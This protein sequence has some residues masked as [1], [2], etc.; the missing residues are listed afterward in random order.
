MLNVNLKFIYNDIE[1]KIQANKDEIMKEIFK[2]YISELNK[3]IYN[4]Y[5]LYNGKEINEDLKLEQ[6]NNKDN[7][8]E[9]L[10]LNEKKFKKSLIK[11][12][13]DIIC[14]KCGENCI[15]NIEDY[16]I[17]LNKCDNG[18]EQDNILLNNYYEN[19][20]INDSKILC[21]KC[22][23][24]KLDIYN[25][26]FYICC[27]CNINLCPSCK[28]SHNGE[29]LILNYE[30]KNY[31]CNLHGE[32]YISFCKECHKNFCNLCELKHN[33]IH[34]VIK[35][36][37][38][39][40]CK[41]DIQNNLN[42]LKL[43]I[44][45]FKKEIQ[46][47][48][49]KLNNVIYNIEMYYNIGNNLLNN[50]NKKNENYQLLINLNNINKYNKNIIEDIDQIIDENNFENKFKYINEIYEKMLAKEEMVIKYKIEKEVG[51]IRLFGDKFVENNKNN[52]R[53]IINN[54]MNKLESFIDIKENKIEKGIL[55]IKLKKLNEVTDMSYIFSKCSSLYELSNI[56]KWSTNN[57]TQMK[58]MFNNCI[59]LKFLPDFSQWNTNNVTNMYGMFNKCTSLKSL[60]DI[61][62][63][64]TNNVIDMKCM[65]NKCSSLT[66]L[67]DISSWNTSNVTN[68]YG[69]FNQCSSLKS[70]PD[71]S[72]WNIS[73]VNNMLD[74]FNKCSL[75]KSIPNFSKSNN[76]DNV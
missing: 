40:I 68:M 52:C 11:Q 64:N 74:M 57:V 31:I 59:L 71:I 42:E 23:K 41:D 75:L 69:M 26:E 47:I 55:E 12:S 73:N 76:N 66:S 51:K 46:E 54:K 27:I 45:S 62:K 35:F 50:L 25:N 6:I 29:H 65:F 18:H 30:F 3:D 32:K 36:R 13:T 15:I 22:N 34:K 38:I 19:K 33:Q 2:R 10:V 8:I 28:S 58:L 63:W 4:I 39:N 60:P 7:D 43:K 72:K 14:P 70:L 20:K 56:S 1:I 9:I 48:V 16:N 21:S 17:T 61:S 5:F 49:N 24:K 44:H 67:P 53:I 37:E